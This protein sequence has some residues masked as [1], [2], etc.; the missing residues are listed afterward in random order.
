[1]MIGD[2]FRVC[3]LKLRTLDGDY[4]LLFVTIIK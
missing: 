3:P 1:M 4:N 2:V